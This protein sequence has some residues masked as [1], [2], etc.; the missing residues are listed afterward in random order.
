M[1]IYVGGGE[2]D[3]FPD[4]VEYSSIQGVLATDDR[5]MC[6]NCPAIPTEP[7]TVSPTI[8]PTDFPTPNPTDVPTFKP[9]L[10]PTPEPTDF[11]TFSPT[12]YPTFLPT[13]TPTPR[14]ILC[15]DQRCAD[16]DFVY[17]CWNGQTGCASQDDANILINIGATCGLCGEFT[18]GFDYFACPGNDQQIQFCHM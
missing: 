1:C 3:F 6:G 9:T 5:N 15:M 12:V 10:D 17:M 13:F 2:F 16:N 7:P 8:T 4:C 18:C 11:P 14:P